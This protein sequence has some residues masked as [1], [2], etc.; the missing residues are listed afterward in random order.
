MGTQLFKLSAPLMLLILTFCDSA[1]A[2]HQ[3]GESPTKIKKDIL[4]SFLF[5]GAEMFYPDTVFRPV[6]DEPVSLAISDRAVLDKQV[7]ALF[8]KLMKE[9]R[10]KREV[11]AAYFQRDLPRNLKT[12]LLLTNNHGGANI[13]PFGNGYAIRFSQSLIQ[14]DYRASLITALTP[15]VRTARHQSA[16]S[17][18]GR[19]TDTTVTELQVFEALKT[20]RKNVENY[21]PTIPNLFLSNFGTG[22]DFMSTYFQMADLGNAMEVLEKQYLG[23]LLFALAHEMG[24]AAFGTV[25]KPDDAGEEW[26]RQS[27]IDADRFATSLLS[28]VFMVLGVQ[29]MTISNGYNTGNL[30][31]L[32]KD[33]TEGF[34]GYGIFFDKGYELTYQRYPG[35]NP[36]YYPKPEARLAAAKEVFSVIFAADKPKI[37]AKFERRQYWSVLTGGIS[38]RIEEAFGFL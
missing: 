26:F 38:K 28:N 16:D 8:E 27:E 36:G 4:S 33:Y 23:T 7:Q 35:Y 6:S 9:Y 1:N 5:K 22:I 19:G 17:V 32:Y 20:V 29:T 21:N 15:A 18:A 34:L 37:I 13:Q 14:S 12:Q 30:Y 2:Q 10:R 25:V 11:I 3:I 31:F 24:H